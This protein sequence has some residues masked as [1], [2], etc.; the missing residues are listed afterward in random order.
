MK[1]VKLI[2]ELMG[3]D[4]EMLSRVMSNGHVRNELVQ[5]LESGVW[6]RSLERTYQFLDVCVK[7][8][9]SHSGIIRCL[10]A[11][12]SKF[13]VADRADSYFLFMLVNDG[14]VKY[15]AILSREGATVLGGTSPYN[16]CRTQIIAFLASQ[17]EN[18]QLLHAAALSWQDAGLILAGRGM[19]GKSTLVLALL[20]QG[21]RYFSDDI[22]ALRNDSCQLIPFP[23][24]I[25]VR[26]ES[27]ALL[28]SLLGEDAICSISSKY[29]K[30]LGCCVL[31]PVDGE[32]GV[33]CD[34]RHF[35]ILKGFG[36]QPRLERIPP[37][38]AIAGAMLLSLTCI[39]RPGQSSRS[40]S[41]LAATL[42]K[43]ECYELYPGPL[44]ETVCA[45]TKILR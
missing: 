12:Y 42:S 9:A 38:R 19:R 20:A 33:S 35:F 30:S 11:L 22:A 32:I 18:H 3:L 25:S 15:T 28:G 6:D 26:P 21:F 2:D 31:E 36:N 5:S 45:L 43:A 8:R 39:G 1:S 27:L 23:K 4:P 37:A 41:T 13:T 10:D 17:L 24:A 34:V 16:L 40:L 7:V 44:D 29:E 14:R